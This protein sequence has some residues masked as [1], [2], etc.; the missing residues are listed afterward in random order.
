MRGT[1]VL[2]AIGLL[3]VAVLGGMLKLLRV[4]ARRS[5]PA[6]W[7]LAGVGALGAVF[8]LVQASRASDMVALGWIVL[9]MIAGIL[10]VAAT[11]TG[12][13]LRGRAASPPPDVDPTGPDLAGP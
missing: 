7:I 8:G 10:S 2:L 1:L 11:I 3:P 12:I 5:V 4:D 9:A 6:F 13:V